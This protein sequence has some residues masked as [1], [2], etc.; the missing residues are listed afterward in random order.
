MNY[1]QRSDASINSMLAQDDNLSQNAPTDW[2][3]AEA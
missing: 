3:E 1:A 2:H